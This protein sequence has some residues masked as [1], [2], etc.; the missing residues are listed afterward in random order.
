MAMVA[1]LI[2]PNSYKKSHHWPEGISFQSAKSPSKSEL[3]VTIAH[4]SSAHNY[5]CH[6]N[7]NDLGH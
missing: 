1:Q 4:Y 7:Q 6:Y 5:Y 2:N 3:G